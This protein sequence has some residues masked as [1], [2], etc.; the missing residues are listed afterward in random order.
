[1]KK[2]LFLSILLLSTQAH[3][4]AILSAGYSVINAKDLVDPS[5]LE[6]AF[7][8]NEKL[9]SKFEYRLTTSYSTNQYVTLSQTAMMEVFKNFKIGFGPALSASYNK[10]LPEYGALNSSFRVMAEM[11][12]W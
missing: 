3:A 5:N 8:V 1:M 7:N 12:L 11:R 9:N 2:L 10:G 6:L 4:Q